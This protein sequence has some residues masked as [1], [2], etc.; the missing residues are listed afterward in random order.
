MPL[1]A[2]LRYLIRGFCTSA[3]APP[4]LFRWQHLVPAFPP[5][6]G[7]LAL[8]FGY[9]LAPCTVVRC[10]WLGRGTV[11]GAQRRRETAMRVSNWKRLLPTRHCR[12]SVS[13][14]R[15]QYD[16]QRLAAGRAVLCGP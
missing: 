15:L 12:H 3:C 6:E 9:F 16:D 5:G 11:H 7:F 2:R 8:R 1:S 10:G 4:E 13:A 14:V